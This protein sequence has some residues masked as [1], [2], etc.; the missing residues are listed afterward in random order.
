PIEL[1]ARD[2]NFYRYAENNSVQ[3]SD[4]LGLKSESPTPPP[5]PCSAMGLNC[6]PCPPDGYK[7]YDPNNCPPGTY[8]PQ[9]DNWQDKLRDFLRDLF[10][11]PPQGPHDLI[12]DSP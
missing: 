9:E 7:P 8:C 6:D 5:S 10:P 2:V 11:H 1:R 3:Q 12:P 4:P